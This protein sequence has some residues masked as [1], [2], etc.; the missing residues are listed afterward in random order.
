MNV[1]IEKSEALGIIKAPPSKSIAHRMLIGA[2]LADGKSII[3]GIEMSGD[4]SATV[5]CLKEMGAKIEI[6]GTTAT[7]WGMDIS[8]IKENITLNCNESGSTLRF[9]VP[10]S[11]AV[12]KKVNFC[13]SKTLFSRPLTVYEE[14][15]KTENINYLKTEET[16]W[17]KGK[18]KGG[19]YKVKGNISSQFISGLLFLLPLIEKDSEI[20]IIPPIESVSY[21]KLTIAA[22]EKFGIKI[23]WKDERT[24]FIPGKQKYIPC[25]SVVEGDYSNTAFFDAM[26]YLSSDIKIEGLNPESM[27]GDMAYLRHFPAI[28]RGMPTINISDCP[29]LGPV[30]FALSGVK[31][32]GVFTGTRRLKI[33]ESDRAGA[34]AQELSKF[35]IKVNV[36]EDTVIVYPAEFYPPKE[37]LNSHNDHRIVMA[38]TVLLMLTGGEIEGAEAVNKSFPGFFDKLREL[39]VKF[40]IKVNENEYDI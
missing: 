23:S 13:G 36:M 15:F 21:I 3:K 12:D 4:V 34:M 30:L 29:D 6:E 27:Q 37:K 10:L 8:K 35:G 26:N 9:F 16:L 31:S 14:I 33:K 5:S 24:L 38:L 28:E 19:N 1:K 39:N 2:G 40:E 7:V 18:L 25:D 11:L 17:V 32:G 22:L 20:N